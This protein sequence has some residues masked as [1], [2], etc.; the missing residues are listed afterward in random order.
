MGL[1][2]VQ[3]DAFEESG[4]TWIW[5]I[6]HR[7]MFREVEHAVKE[8]GL[9]APAIIDY[10]ACGG[11]VLKKSKDV[12]P[13]AYPFGID[14]TESSVATLR[15]FGLNGQVVDLEEPLILDRE[16]DVAL[17]GEIIE[18]IINT[19]VFL[20]SI[21]RSLRMGGRLILSFPNVAHICSSVMQVIFDLPAIY[22]ARYR[23]FHVRNYTYRIVRALLEAHRFRI[24]RHFGTQFPNAPEWTHHIARPF[25]RLGKNIIVVAEKVGAP[26]D[27]M[28]DGHPS[29]SIFGVLEYLREMAA[30]PT[31]PA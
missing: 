21:N 22:S 8:M 29:D 3:I 28:L 10:A 24:I 9:S 18:H 26:H 27:A 19:D 14:I 15:E 30:T 25:P 11:E 4:R 7:L 20:C 12:Y 6:R 23:G 5:D 31:P 1:A 13:D 17:A 16:F 2:N